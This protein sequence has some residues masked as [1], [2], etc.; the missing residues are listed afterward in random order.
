MNV[1]VRVWVETKD[2]PVLLKQATEEQRKA[3]GE[4]ILKKFGAA[5][6][7]RGVTL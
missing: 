4:K 6:D 5:I 1:T 7:E 3:L 2:G